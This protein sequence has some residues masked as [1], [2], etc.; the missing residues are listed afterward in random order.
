MGVG[1]EMELGKI[2]YDAETKDLIIPQNILARVLFSFKLEMV[3][4]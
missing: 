1:F 4:Y 2:E 3:I